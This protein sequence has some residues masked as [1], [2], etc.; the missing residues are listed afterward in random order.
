MEISAKSAQLCSSWRNTRCDTLSLRCFER[1]DQQGASPEVA[2]LGMSLVSG[3]S[4]LGYD[5]AASQHRQ[6]EM[7]DQ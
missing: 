6:S 7:P 3:S 2:V 4:R 1:D 5:H